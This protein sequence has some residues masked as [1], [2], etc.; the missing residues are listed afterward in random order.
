MSNVRK[1]LPARTALST[2]IF[3]VMFLSATA[4]LAAPSAEHG[5]TEFPDYLWSAGF[6]TWDMSDPANPRFVDQYT[7]AGQIIGDPDHEEA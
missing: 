6:Q 7:T 3:L 4:G 5:L 1:Q 2:A